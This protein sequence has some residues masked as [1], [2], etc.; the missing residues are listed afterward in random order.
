MNDEPEDLSR[1]ACLVAELAKMPELVSRLIAEH[2]DD[3]R[4]RCIRCTLPGRGTP[5][6][7]WPCG[8]VA[9]AIAAQDI[10]ARTRSRADLAY[11]AR[12]WHKA[13]TVPSPEWMCEVTQ[14]PV[15]GQP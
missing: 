13:G 6:E 1:W 12:T 8:P 7:R 5:G 11:P 15:R 2:R 3:G 9:L 14:K 10:V 4:G